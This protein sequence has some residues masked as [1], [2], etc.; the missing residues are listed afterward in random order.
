MA[1][2]LEAVVAEVQDRLIPLIELPI[3]WFGRLSERVQDRLVGITLFAPS[4]AVLAT[5]AW[6]TPDPSGMGTHRQLGLGGCAV[7]TMTGLPCPMC[8]MTT[9]FTHMAHFQVV[10]ALLNQ[11]FGPVLFLCTVAAALIGGTRPAGAQAAVA[12]RAGG[13]RATRDRHRG[14]PARGHG[15]GLGVQGGAGAGHA[16]LGVMA[17][18]GVV[19]LA[20]HLGTDTPSTREPVLR[21]GRG[22][23]GTRV[24]HAVGVARL[25]LE[26][27][28][29]V[30]CS[31]RGR[32]ALDDDPRL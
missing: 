28:C 12:T 8:G 4:A 16:A 15:R 7:L 5:A 19:T 13:R 6:L 14:V 9:T 18:Q 2:K 1:G 31:V 26:H 17:A 29:A 11:P 24:D 20:T 27:A 21:M 25:E 30:P 3:R 22:P 32:S 23:R 10:E